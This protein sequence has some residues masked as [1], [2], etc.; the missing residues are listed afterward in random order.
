VY[1]NLGAIG[2]NMEKLA[3]RHLMVVVQY[4]PD[5]LSENILKIHYPL[6]EAYKVCEQFNN[7][8]A[9]AYVLI[10]SGRNQ[11]GVLLICDLFSLNCR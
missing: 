2:K 7:K 11:E 1:S 4:C 8:T 5:K 3:V 6:E 10:K 9:M